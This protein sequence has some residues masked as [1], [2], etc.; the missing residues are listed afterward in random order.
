MKKLYLIFGLLFLVTA[1]LSGCA[2]KDN[3]VPLHSVKYYTKHQKQMTAMIKECNKIPNK[4]AYK[5]QATHL[6]MDCANANSA[7]SSLEQY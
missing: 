4:T 6:G 2:N 5:I 3:S 1:G 7:Q